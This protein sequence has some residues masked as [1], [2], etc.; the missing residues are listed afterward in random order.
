MENKQNV[1]Y[2]L[3]RAIFVMNDNILVLSVNDTRTFAILSI[4]HDK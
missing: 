1:N 3:F 2:F 4:I